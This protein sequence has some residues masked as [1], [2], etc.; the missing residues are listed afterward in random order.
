MSLDDCHY[1]IPTNIIFKR[2][3]MILKILKIFFYNTIFIIS[4]TTIDGV[5]GH[6][7]DSRWR[8]LNFRLC[9][10]RSISG[11]KSIDSPVSKLEL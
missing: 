10:Q 8:A 4:R 3:T 11:W 7:K 2:L 6:S 5:C 9:H 1:F